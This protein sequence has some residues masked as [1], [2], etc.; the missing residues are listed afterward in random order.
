MSSTP[1]RS[2]HPL[3]VAK[4]PLADMQAVNIKGRSAA[5]VRVTG[6]SYHRMA[7]VMS[8]TRQSANDLSA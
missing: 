3:S 5:D 8:F 6:L 1:D 7:G 2:L 4:G